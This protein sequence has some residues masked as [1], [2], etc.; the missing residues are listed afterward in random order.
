MYNSVFASLALSITYQQLVV[1]STVEKRKKQQKV[2]STFT[3]T[4]TFYSNSAI[5][6]HWD[7]GRECR[8]EERSEGVLDSE[9]NI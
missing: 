9:I 3:F 8:G 5:G 1:V 2:K 4:P 7:W 6:T